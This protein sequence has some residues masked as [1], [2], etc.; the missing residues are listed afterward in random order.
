VRSIRIAPSVAPAVIGGHDYPSPP[1]GSD[2]FSAAKFSKAGLIASPRIYVSTTL[3]TLH[4]W[5]L[6][7]LMRSLS[8]PPRHLAYAMSFFAIKLNWLPYFADELHQSELRPVG[9]WLLLYNVAQRSTAWI[10]AVHNN[11]P[12]FSS[13]M[14]GASNLLDW[15]YSQ[16]MSSLGLK[17]AQC[18]CVVSDLATRGGSNLTY[19]HEQKCS[20]LILALI[21]NMGIRLFRGR[22]RPAKP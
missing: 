10:Q 4:G 22:F 12:S 19:G 6:I 18:G 16:L 15:K 13:S 21:E 3:A 11:I 20:R 1:R 2:A 9:L 8:P 7:D 17:Y 5:R 14:R